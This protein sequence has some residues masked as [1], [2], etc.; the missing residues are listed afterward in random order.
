MGLSIYLTIEKDN[1]L[2]LISEICL[3]TLEY[4]HFIFLLFLESIYNPYPVTLYFSPIFS[5]PVY[6]F[7][8]RNLVPL[9]SLDLL[10]Q[11]E[12]MIYQFL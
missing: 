2:F 3:K 10:L 8:C 1:L 12:H 9:H 11:K 4:T 7:Y 5:M 6:T